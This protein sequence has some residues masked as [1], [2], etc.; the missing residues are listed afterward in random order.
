MKLLTIVLVLFSF[1]ASAGFLIEPYAGMG[2]YT[3]TVDATGIDGED[4]EAMSIFGARLGYSFI[5]LS[6]GIDYEVQTIDD[7]SF[8]NTSLFVGVDLPILLRFWGKYIISAQQSADDSSA[9][10]GDFTSGY[11]V[12][13]GFTG[14]PFVSLNLEAQQVSYEY[15]L[16]GSLDDTKIDFANLLFTVSFPINL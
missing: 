14:L 13:L 4:N 12:G 2:N 5:L 15:D 3:S 7:G 10:T 8:T 9:V 1:N 6:A 16:G 11:A